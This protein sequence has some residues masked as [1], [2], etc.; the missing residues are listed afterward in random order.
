MPH[1]WQLLRPSPSSPLS[2]SLSSSPSSGRDSALQP[3]EESPKANATRASP[4]TGEAAA[5]GGAAS[6]A[7]APSAAGCGGATSPAG[8]E[9]LT[10]PAALPLPKRHVSSKLAARM[11]AFEG[12]VKPA[13]DGLLWV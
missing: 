2:P 5:E 13:A 7:V 4:G 6:G 11:A 12:E 1:L 8:L 9:R 3:I 10:A